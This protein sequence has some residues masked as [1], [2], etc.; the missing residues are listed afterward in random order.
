MNE[1]VRECMQ[2][3]IVCK[4]CRISSGVCFWKSLS[5]VLSGWKIW[6]WN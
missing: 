1:L 3:M 5:V 2:E 6:K 4:V